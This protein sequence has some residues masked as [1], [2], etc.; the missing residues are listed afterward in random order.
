MENDQEADEGTT[1]TEDEEEIEIDRLRPEEVNIVWI[2]LAD[3]LKK[4][5]PRMHLALTGQQPMLL[6]DGTTLQVAFRNNALLAEFKQDFKFKF[7]AELREELGNAFLE[8]EEII[9]SPDEKSQA[10]YYTNLDK[11]KHM[12]KKN[13]ALQKLKQDFNLDFE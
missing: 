3:E 1:A 2:K 8:I 13:P 4:D 6:D 5:S 9:L 12:M 11:L 7:L 10:K